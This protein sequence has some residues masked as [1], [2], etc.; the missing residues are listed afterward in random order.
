MDTRKNVSR[1]ARERINEYT[2]I[3]DK[4]RICIRCGFE[5]T[6]LIDAEHRYCETCNSNYAII[7]SNKKTK[8]CIIS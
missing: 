7:I 2:D 6:S 8:T 1:F 4:N 3:D 5:K